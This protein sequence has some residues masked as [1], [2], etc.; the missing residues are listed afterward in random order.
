MVFC[1]MKSLCDLGLEGGEVA[2]QLTKVGPDQPQL[3]Q[4]QIFSALRHLHPPTVQR[5]QKPP[6]AP[7]CAR[8]ATITTQASDSGRN[9]FQPIRISWS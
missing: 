1:A 2:F 3:L 5:A 8:K 9:T 7:Y 6:S 4:H